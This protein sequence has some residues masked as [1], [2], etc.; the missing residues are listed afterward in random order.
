M[1]NMLDLMKEPIEVQVK[2]RRTMTVIVPVKNWFYFMLKLEYFNDPKS[3]K[4]S[5]EIPDFL[6]VRYLNAISDLTESL[7]L[8]H[9]L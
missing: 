6:L 4:K 8:G 1:E 7:V 2:A 9:C 3:G 5:S